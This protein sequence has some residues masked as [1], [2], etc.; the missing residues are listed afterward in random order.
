MKM[1]LSRYI[2]KR[3]G[4]VQGEIPQ[5]K[6]MLRKS[7]TAANFRTFW[8]YWN[9]IYSYVLT[10]YVY[11]PL[12][13]YMPQRLARTLTFIV[14]GVFHDIVVSL[15]LGRFFYGVTLLFMTYIILLTIEEG[16][17]IN[18]EHKVLGVIYN[19]IMLIGPFLGVMYIV[20]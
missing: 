19:L 11:R 2:D 20:N 3:L 4:G 1:T 5:L 12:K 16:L 6:Q 18:I 10:Y 7:F 13:Q 17:R 8:F 9:P 14:N 15:V